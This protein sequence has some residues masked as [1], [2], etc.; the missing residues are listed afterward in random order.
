MHPELTAA[1]QKSDNL[2]Y[3]DPSVIPVLRKHA[4]EAIPYY[5]EILKRATPENVTE[6]IDTGLWNAIFLMGE[7]HVEEAF[8]HLV[9]VFHLDEEATN[10]FGDMITESLKDVLYHTYNGDID[11]LCELVRSRETDYFV[12]D[13]ALNTIQ[14]LYLDGILPGKAGRVSTGESAG[15]NQS[16]GRS[17]TYLVQHRVIPPVR[18]GEGAQRDR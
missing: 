1:I 12:R 13:A 11:A 5:L 7:N 14:Q 18:A 17:N 4:D 3:F 2:N 6:L 10:Y 8:P 15:T 9:R 16:R